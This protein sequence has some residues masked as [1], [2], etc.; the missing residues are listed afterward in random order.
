MSNNVITTLLGTVATL[1]FL[2]MLFAFIR[3]INAKKDTVRVFT[4]KDKS[5]TVDPADMNEDNVELEE[6]ELT[7]VTP[8]PARAPRQ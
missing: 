3:A 2:T 6:Q 4:I 5:C 7:D 8:R 1:Q